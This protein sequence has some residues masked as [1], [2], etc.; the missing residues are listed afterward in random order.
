MHIHVASTKLLATLIWE[1]VSKPT[2]VDV[3][4]ACRSGQASGL[5]FNWLHFLLDIWFSYVTV[6]EIFYFPSVRLAEIH[7]LHNERNYKMFT[8]REIT[9]RASVFNKLVESSIER[10]LKNYFSFLL[11][12]ARRRFTIERST[13]KA[14]ISGHEYWGKL[15]T[16]DLKE[17]FSRLT[18][19]RHNSRSFKL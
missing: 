7:L 1:K 19:N 17:K 10:K 3:V 18:T 14:L 16:F 4:C 5:Y 8:G 6:V 13:T 15:F 2:C 12:C 9:L 11:R